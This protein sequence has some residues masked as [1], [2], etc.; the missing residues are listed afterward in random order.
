M[1]DKLEPER[2]ENK[3]EEMDNNELAKNSRLAGV[4]DKANSQ[5]LE[6]GGAHLRRR[7]IAVYPHP[8][9]R[10]E[11]ALALVRRH[12]HRGDVRTGLSLHFLSRKCYVD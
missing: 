1:E 12:L 2:K 4:A 9:G 11:G 7:E 8:D 5:L 3:T 10:D 6:W